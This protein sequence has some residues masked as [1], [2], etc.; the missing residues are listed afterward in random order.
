M[1]ALFD[2]GYQLARSGYPWKHTP[3]GASAPVNK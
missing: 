2:Y 1:K 3:P